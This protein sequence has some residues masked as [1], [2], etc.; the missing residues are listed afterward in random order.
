MF[1]SNECARG[2][3]VKYAQRLRSND[4]VEFF[5]MIGIFRQ[6]QTVHYHLHL[7]LR[8]PLRLRPN[9][10]LDFLGL[11]ILGFR[12]PRPQIPIKKKN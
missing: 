3:F 5:D 6:I 12:P 10:D 7:P 2:G 9:I 1:T 4:S 8:M 11:I